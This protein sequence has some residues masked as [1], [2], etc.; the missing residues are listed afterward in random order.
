MMLMA[1]K[2]YNMDIQVR[3]AEN[4]ELHEVVKLSKAFEDEHI[5]NGLVADDYEYFTKRNVI[6][7]IV[8]KKVVGYCYGTIDTKKRRLAYINEG[9]K[10][11]YLDEIYV[12][13]EYRSQGIGRKLFEYIEKY[14]KVNGCEAMELTSASK[15]YKAALKF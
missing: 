11:L 2:G 12:K 14:A 10:Y 1:L 4:D 15:D 13:K 5:C 9:T 8:D 6:I 3:F 7:A